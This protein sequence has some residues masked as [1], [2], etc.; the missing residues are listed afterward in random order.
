MASDGVGTFRVQTR[1]LGVSRSTWVAQKMFAGVDGI[2]IGACRERIG[3]GGL[4]SKVRIKKI[5]W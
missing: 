5:K 3:G 2:K 1:S 4:R